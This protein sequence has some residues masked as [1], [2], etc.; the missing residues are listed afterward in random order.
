MSRTDACYRLTVEECDK[1][2]EGIV[3]DRWSKARLRGKKHEG[4]DLY[5]LSEAPGAYKDI[6][7]VIKAEEDLVEATV[8]LMPLA[9]LKG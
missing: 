7:E 8:R 1:A 5:D 4:A 6:E 3:C 2:M 9:V